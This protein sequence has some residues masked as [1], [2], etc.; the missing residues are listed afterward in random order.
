MKTY[1]AEIELIDDDKT[2]SITEIR[3]SLTLK[4]EYSEDGRFTMKLSNMAQEITVMDGNVGVILP[5]WEQ[6]LR[7][8]KE[9]DGARG[10]E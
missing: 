7:E 2:L 4:I 1:R 6:H 9:D 5:I 3:S 10:S 8:Q